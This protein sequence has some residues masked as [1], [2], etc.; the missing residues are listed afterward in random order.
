MDGGIGLL[1]KRLRQGRVHAPESHPRQIGGEL[2]LRIG[3]NLQAFEIGIVDFRHE[4]A[5]FFAAAVPE[6]KARA[7]IAGIAAIFRFRRLLEHDDFVGA[8]LSSRDR[9]LEGGASAADDDDVAPLHRGQDGTLSVRASRAG[10]S[11]SSLNSAS[12]Y[13]C[14]ETSNRL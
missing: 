12:S 14:T 6:S 4:G 1:D 9:G 7:G 10:F 8:V 11:R 13:P 3:R 2:F 5:N